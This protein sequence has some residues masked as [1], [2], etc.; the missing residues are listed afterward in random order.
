MKNDFK[1]LKAPGDHRPMSTCSKVRDGRPRLYYIL[2]V[3]I[4]YFSAM[5]KTVL[6]HEHLLLSEQEIDTLDCFRKFCCRNTP[7]ICCIAH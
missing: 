3:I 2:I 4:G 6:E 7:A 5:V 1:D